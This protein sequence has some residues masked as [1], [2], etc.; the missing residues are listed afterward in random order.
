MHISSRKFLKLAPLGVFALAVLL[1]PLVA[2]ADFGP[3]HAK[4]GV[5]SPAISSVQHVARHG[6]ESFIRLADGHADICKA[7]EDTCL[8]GCDGATSCSDQCRKNYDGCMGQ[9][10]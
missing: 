8:Q 6:G 9:N 3:N 1:S 4:A 2:G 10:Q 5:Q 7:N